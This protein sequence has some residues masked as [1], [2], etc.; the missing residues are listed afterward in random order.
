MVEDVAYENQWAVF[1]CLA[2]DPVLIREGRR[3]WS[4][5]IILRANYWTCPTRPRR[6]WG[7]ITC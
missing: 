6:G 5:V 3:R 2:A 4:R 7:E 1:P